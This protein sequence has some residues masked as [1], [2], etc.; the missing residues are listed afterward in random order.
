MSPLYRETIENGSVIRII[1]RE[2]A[3]ARNAQNQLVKSKDAIARS[4]SG[5]K[6]A[7]QAQP[8]RTF[9]ATRSDNLR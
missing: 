9:K 7:G 5:Y 8:P 2:Q 3:E 6:Q 1:T 4:V